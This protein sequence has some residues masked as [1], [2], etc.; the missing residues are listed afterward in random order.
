MAQKINLQKIHPVQLIAFTVIILAAMY[1]AASILNLIFLGLLVA[2]SLMPLINWQ[3]KHRVPKGLAIFTTLFLFLI[4]ILIIDGII[5]G[6]VYE[7]AEKAPEY[8]K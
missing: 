1:A 2:I 4:V 8:R 7:L 3:L 5:I 6:A